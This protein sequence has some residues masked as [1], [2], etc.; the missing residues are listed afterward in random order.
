MLYFLH[1][2]LLFQILITRG[3]CRITNHSPGFSSLIEQVISNT[4]SSFR[5]LKH[6]PANTE[7]EALPQKSTLQAG[8]T[9]ELVDFETKFI[10]YKENMKFILRLFFLYIYNKRYNSNNPTPFLWKMHSERSSFALKALCLKMAP[11]EKA[12]RWTWMRWW[13]KKTRVD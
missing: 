10:F 5:S 6:L 1:S 13:Y 8:N 4:W 3:K 11:M 2:S 12:V 9:T 7:V